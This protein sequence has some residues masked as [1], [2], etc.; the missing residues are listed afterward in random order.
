MEL[1]IDMGLGAWAVVLVAALVFGI[2]AQFIG[3]TRTGLE[4]LIDAIAFALGAIV[5]SEFVIGWRAIDPVWDN[6]A[7]IPAVLGGLVL[8]VI[9]EVAT[10][11]LTG[12]NY[13]GTEGP[14]AA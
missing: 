11:L 2:A 3:D 12:G 6:L 14:M 7:L 5:A 1:A 4:W 8:G 13:R 10:R 9:V